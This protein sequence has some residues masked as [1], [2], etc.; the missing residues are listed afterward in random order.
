M[1][2]R[3]SGILESV[4]YADDIEAMRDFYTRVFDLEVVSYEPDENVFLRCASQ[5]LLI[6]NPEHTR[7]QTVFVGKNPIPRHGVQG[8]AHLAFEMSHEQVN[9]WK[10]KLAQLDIAVESDVHWPNGARSIYM[11]DPAG[12]SIELVTADLWRSSDQARRI[13]HR[14]KDENGR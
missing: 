9:G 11:R 5:M 14:I 12:H 4:L 3:P 8:P 10:A 7:E 2:L 6:F 1:T 13:A